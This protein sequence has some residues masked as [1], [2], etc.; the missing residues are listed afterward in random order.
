MENKTSVRLLALKSLVRC[1]K[2]KRFA[3]LEI[4]ALLSKTSLTSA[5]KKLYTALVYGV[6][7]K[8][9]MLDY[10]IAPYIK[11]E[12][13][14]LDREV[15]TALRLGAL[16]MFFFEK[17]PDY[18]VIN[19]TVEAVKS[20]GVRSASGLVNA[21][22]RALAKNK[23]E[24]CDKIKSAPMSVRYSMP[25]WIIDIYKSSYGEEKALEILEGFNTR[26]PITLHTNTLKISTD[27]LLARLLED[28]F[29][30]HVSELHEDIIVLDTGC[31]EDITGFDEGLFFVQ[32]IPSALCI[33]NL[34]PNPD[35]ILVDTC[36]C[37]GGK[38]F[39]SAVQMKNRGKIY[40]FDIHSSKLSLITSG[41]ERLGISIIETGERDARE[42]NSALFGKCDFVVVD[43]PCSGLGVIS[44][45]PDIRRKSYDDIKRLPEIQYDI[46]KSASKLL[47]VGGRLLYSTCTLNKLENED[48]TDKFLESCEGFE[49]L[50][51]FPK[52]YFPTE[53]TGDGFFCDILTRT[54]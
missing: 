9:M 3:N 37:P 34:S 51:G 35:A 50:S 20:A 14:R 26:P 27:T 42:D 30:A 46:L 45:K 12:I 36:A 1:E 54:K 43:A 13:S 18:S 32:G 39:A 29:K 16:Q 48:V 6:I 5:D 40:S 47:K 17:I 19:E 7:E 28:G 10:I 52:T 2:E 8:E 15:Q 23:A 25:E 41:A 33:K 21:V 11:G 53:E 4:N 38:S 24:I 44:K 22:L 49:R 31:A